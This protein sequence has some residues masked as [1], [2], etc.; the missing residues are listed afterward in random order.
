MRLAS[1]LDKVVLGDEGVPM[2]FQS[3]LC[4][5]AILQFA[6]GPFIDDLVVASVGKECGLRVSTNK[7][8]R[9]MWRTVMKLSS[10]SHCSSVEA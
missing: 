8:M 3:A 6:E 1:N 5:A 4:S 2:L 7:D 10:T 9:I